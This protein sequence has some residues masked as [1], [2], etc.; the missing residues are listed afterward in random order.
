M[1]AFRM[2][3][4]QSQRSFEKGLL[5]PFAV[6]LVPSTRLQIMAKRFDESFL[7]F[8]I[9][10]APGRLRTANAYIEKL[11]GTRVKSF[12]KAIN[13]INGYGNGLHFRLAAK[14]LANIINRRI[15]TAFNSH[16]FR[17]VIRQPIT[18]QRIAVESQHEDA[19]ARD[20]AQFAQSLCQIAPLMH[21]HQR[22]GRIH[23][24]IVKRQFLGNAVNGRREMR[25]TLGPHRTRRL[26]SQNMPVLRLIRASARPDVE[27]DSS[28]AESLKHQRSD[29][30]I[31]AALPRI[32]VTMSVVVEIACNSLFQFAWLNFNSRKPMGKRF[33]DFFCENRC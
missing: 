5:S 20:S 27:H 30:R 33:R 4:D 15:A 12:G 23:R 3:D 28:G 17:R 13:A 29:P 24:F 14:A 22:H 21:R 8:F 16:E 2:T 31:R 19:V 11:F 1:P 10:K 7:H 26:D 25:R 6:S 32:S 18:I 9:H